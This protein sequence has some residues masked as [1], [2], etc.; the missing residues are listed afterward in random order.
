MG[1]AKNAMRREA[2]APV[3]PPTIHGGKQGRTRETRVK[4]KRKHCNG[5]RKA[6]RE[7]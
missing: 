4:K 6:T 3:L 1:T 2:Q 7:V 5:K